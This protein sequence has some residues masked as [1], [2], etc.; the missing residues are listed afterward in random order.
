MKHHRLGA[1][2]AS[3]SFVFLWAFWIL[4]IRTT[5]S[6]MMQHLVVLIFVIYGTLT[7]FIGIHV[8]VA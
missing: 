6:Q 4:M 2:I 5:H 3:I 1:H 8:D 7:W